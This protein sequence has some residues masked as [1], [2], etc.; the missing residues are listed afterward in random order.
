VYYACDRRDAARAG[1][2][3]DYIYHELATPLAERQKAITQLLR[4]EGLNAFR[5]W[6]DRADK[7]AY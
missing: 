4:D 3:D 5:L 6:R 1:F 2:D 7:V